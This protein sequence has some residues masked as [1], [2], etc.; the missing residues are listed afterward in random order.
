MKNLH[1]VMI[2]LKGLLAHQVRRGRSSCLRL[3]AQSVQQNFLGSLRLVIVCL[4][5]YVDVR[6]ITE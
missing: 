5:T 2:A 1:I 6:L 3:Q 4:V